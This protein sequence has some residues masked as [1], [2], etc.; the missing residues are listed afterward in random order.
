MKDL[1]LYNG[2]LINELLE[3]EEF[4]SVDCIEGVLLDDELFYNHNNKKYYMCLEYAL[5]SWSSC[6]KVYCGEM[7]EIYEKW[8]ERKKEIVA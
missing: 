5:N 8:N 7:K 2:N 4:E 3:K 1:G 6:Y